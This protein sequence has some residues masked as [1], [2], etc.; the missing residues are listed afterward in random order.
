MKTIQE[1]YREKLDKKTIQEA[2]NLTVALLG[3]TRDAKFDDFMTRLGFFITGDYEFMRVGPLVP[4]E[5]SRFAPCMA[6][7]TLKE[8]IINTLIKG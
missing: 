7:R 5:E 3:Y 8:H 2:L 1:L 6:M 4:D